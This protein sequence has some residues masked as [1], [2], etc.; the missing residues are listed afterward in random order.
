MKPNE[1]KTKLEQGENER[2][3]LPEGV[4]VYSDPIDD[5][6]DSGIVWYKTKGNE[7]EKPYLLFTFEQ[8]A[9]RDKV[10]ARA[11]FEVGRVQGILLFETMADPITADDYLQ[12]EEFKELT[13]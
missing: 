10:I 6:A 7:F 11:A 12:S 9:E 3:R 5:K 13:K 1:S 4:P 2:Q 8:L